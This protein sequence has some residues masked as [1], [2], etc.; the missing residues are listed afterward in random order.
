MNGTEKL[1]RVK[2]DHVL[3]T[4]PEPFQA[5]FNRAKVH[6][7]RRFDRAFRSGQTIALREFDPETQEY[8]G[9]V[10]IAGIMHITKPGTFGLPNDVGVMSIRVKELWA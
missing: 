7:V 4:W 2:V 10:V 6:E 9:R 5:V 3:K 1:R 8:S